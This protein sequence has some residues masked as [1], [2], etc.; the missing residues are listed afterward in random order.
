MFCSGSRWVLQIGGSL[1]LAVAAGLVVTVVV[2]LWPSAPTPEEQ[3]PPCYSLGQHEQPVGPACR[4]YRAFWNFGFER[5][6]RAGAGRRAGDERIRPQR[7]RLQVR[8]SRPW[9]GRT[10]QPNHHRPSTTRLRSRRFRKTDHC[11]RC[12][13]GTAGPGRNPRPPAAR[14]NP[15]PEPGGSPRARRAVRRRAVR[16]RASWRVVNS[17]A[18]L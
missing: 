15:P 11:R 16:R 12:G 2:W 8:R 10:R 18:R 13:C 17:P 7:H 9:L 1:A 3:S 4:R 5:N 14:R 6:S